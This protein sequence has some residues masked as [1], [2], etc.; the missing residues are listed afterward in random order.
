MTKKTKTRNVLILI[1]TTMSYRTII[2]R[3]SISI[4]R[5]N[6]RLKTIYYVEKTNDTFFQNFLKKNFWSKIMMIHT[7][8]ILNTKKRTICWKKNF[9]NNMNKNVKEYVDIR[10]TCHQIK[11]VKHKSHD[12]LQSLFIFEKSRQDWTMN[13]ITNL[14]FSKHKEIVY[15]LILM[16]INHYINFILYIS[17]K[18]TWNVENLTNALINEIFIKF[19]KLVFIVTDREFVFIFKFW[20]SLCYHL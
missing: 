3:M 6:E 16:M 4:Y 9:W 12:M 2:A 1:K 5:L 7:L 13:F 17:L 10:W 8:I 20:L 11:F 18:K 19:E 14:L 15:N